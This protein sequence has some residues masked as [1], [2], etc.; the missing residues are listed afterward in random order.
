MS[1]QSNKGRPN[2][3]E[4]DLTSMTMTI[5]MT[6]TMTMTIE[7]LCCHI[8]NTII[9]ITGITLCRLHTSTH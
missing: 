3:F 4:A 7:I 5:T 9:H 8:R 2:E 1:C 6:I